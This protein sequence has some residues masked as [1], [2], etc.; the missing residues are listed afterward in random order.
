MSALD[1]VIL[2]V[3]LVGIVCVGVYFS[4]R[5][6]DSMKDYFL[7]G[8][9]CRWWMLAA[10]GAAS[11]YDI[12]GTMFLVSL[13]YVV[14]LRAFWMLWS[15][16]FFAAAF[17]MSYMAVWIRRTR[18]MTAVELMRIRFGE[19]RGGRMARTA[20]AMLMVTFLVVSVGYSF[21]G[22]SKFLPVILPEMLIDQANPM[23]SGKMWALIL[24][25]LTT[26]YV[27]A[28]G[29]A[30]VIA[31][32]FIQTVLM[33]IA[34]LLVGA[35]VYF[36]LD[37]AAVQALHAKLQISLAPVAHL[38]LRAGYEGWSDFG[39]LCVFWVF[40]GF[41]I[42]MSG[43]GGHYQEQRFLAT[44]THTDAAKTGWAW[45][46]FLIPRWAMI[47]GFVCIAATGMVGTE[48][49]EQILPIVLVEM[50]P[51]GVRGLIL[52][53]L[54]AAFM[55]T[56]SSVINAAAS[57]I[58]RDLVQPACPRLPERTLVKFSYLAT[59]LVVVLGTVIGFQANTIRGIWV[60][61]IAGLIGGTL[62]PNL[63]RWHWWRLNGW[64]Y[65]CGVF[66][67]L[68]TALAAGLLTYFKVLDPAPA[69]H[70][71]APVIWL[72]TL[73]GCVA[74]SLLTRREDADVLRTF[75]TRVRPWGLWG[76]VRREAGK[77][78]AL[79][80]PDQSWIRVLVNVVLGV[81]CLLSAYVTTFFLVGHYHRLAVMTGSLSLTT[82]VAL[83]VTWYRVLRRFEYE[84]NGDDRHDCSQS[85]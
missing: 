20:G 22:V 58:V 25:G 26:I 51:A 52:A 13:F 28:G 30:G 61:M 17:L 67:G 47:A 42:N 43:A 81:T 19:D 40:M 78:P 7:G 34:G 64:G 56:F 37:P 32:D 18:V 73:L 84:E 75:Y 4:R 16:Q 80:T 54:V 21:A 10:S 85:I 35:V 76:P 11:N 45:G 77:L 15:W 68:A 29:F 5:A 46:F 60:W 57:M 27:T 71:Y 3:Y 50:M 6:A 38:D 36:K 48:D 63:L 72:V 44:R 53:G 12:A 49:P 55:S 14:G 74:G 2:V 79:D 8:N 82:G 1:L 41:F 9:T 69:E 62:I 33:S 66:G 39:V 59:V 83:Y 70:Q 24:M 23:V 31:T 65:S